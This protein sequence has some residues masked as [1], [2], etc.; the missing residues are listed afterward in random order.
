MLYFPADSN[1]NTVYTTSNLSENYLGTTQFPK[2][3]YFVERE[4]SSLKMSEYMSAVKNTG[5]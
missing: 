3:S 1:L 2:W 5:I 4:H